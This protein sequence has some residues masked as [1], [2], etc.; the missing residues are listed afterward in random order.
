MEPWPGM[1]TN[2]I[3]DDSPQGEAVAA[4]AWVAR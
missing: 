4:E 3:E 1:V 2:P